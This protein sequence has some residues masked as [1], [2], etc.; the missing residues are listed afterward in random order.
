MPVQAA[1]PI[2]H[3]TSA[4][5]VGRIRLNAAVLDAVGWLRDLKSS[6]PIDCVIRLG[7]QRQLVITPAD[8]IDE[9]TLSSLETVGYEIARYLASRWEVRLSAE[10]TKRR[11]EFTLPRELRLLKVAPAPNEAAVVF[12]FGDRLEIW[13]GESW[14]AHVTEIEKRRESRRQL[15]E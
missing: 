3:A 2:I 7:P 14:L 5:D 9:P 4:D 13:H 8:L 6:A 1:K 11:R 12:A 15:T 10:P